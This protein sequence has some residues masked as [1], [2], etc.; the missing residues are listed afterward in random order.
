MDVHPL[1][2]RSNFHAV[3]GRTAQNNRLAPPPLGLTFL[4]LRN[5]G[6]VTEFIF[7]S[8]E[9]RHSKQQAARC[10]DLKLC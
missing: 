6:S 8:Q 5:R 7:N 2:F 3:S 10:R 9:K 4:R 1:P